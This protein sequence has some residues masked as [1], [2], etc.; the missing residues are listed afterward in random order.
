[1]QSGSQRRTISSVEAISISVVL[2]TWTI[3]NNI[4]VILWNQNGRKRKRYE[5]I[6]TIWWQDALL[7]WLCVCV[8]ALLSH[9]II[10]V[11]CWM[12]STSLSFVLL[13]ESVHSFNTFLI[14]WNN[15]PNWLGID[16]FTCSIY[17][18]SLSLSLP[19]LRTIDHFPF[20]IR[21]THWYD[22]SDNSSHTRWMNDANEWM[23][24]DFKK[25]NI[26]KRPH[27]LISFILIV[28]S[29][30][31]LITATFQIDPISTC[32]FDRALLT[33]RIFELH[34]MQREQS[35]PSERTR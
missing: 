5:H 7:C 2:I 18:F 30:Y 3:S 12:V 8:R 14:S 28:R 19:T 26:Q 31:T 24:P 10:N 25:K 17:S 9:P 4:S 20:A 35:Q 11:V 13:L 29:A 23:T 32:I 15:L 33:M 21:S 6:H 16:R 27:L 22:Y 1:M 34:A